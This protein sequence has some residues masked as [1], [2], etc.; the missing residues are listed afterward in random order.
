MWHLAQLEVKA[1][2][3]VGSSGLQVKFSKGSTVVV[4]KNGCGKSNLLLAMAFASG[5]GLKEL[6]V[7]HFTELRSLDSDEVPPDHLTS[8]AVE[9]FCE[10][11]EVSVGPQWRH[12]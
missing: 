10:M 3:S 6:G 1:F 8:A 5:A 12:G 7:R 4:G 11:A 2:K 9:D